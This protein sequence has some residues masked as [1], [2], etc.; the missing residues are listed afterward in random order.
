MDNKTLNRYINQYYRLHDDL[1][2]L[3]QKHDDLKAKIIQGM[4]FNGET[5]HTTNQGFKAVIQE[6]HKDYIPMA[7]LKALDIW[8]TE[9]RTTYFKRLTVR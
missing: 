2:A 9:R 4:D 6:S 3:E 7:I 5:T 1:K 8:E